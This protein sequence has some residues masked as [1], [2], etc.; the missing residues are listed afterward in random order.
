MPTVLRKLR[1][2]RV[3]GV[4][5]GANPHA[6]IVLAKRAD[7]NSSTVQR[8]IATARS[9]ISAAAVQK[10]M[11]AEATVIAKAD[12][13]VATGTVKTRA[14]GVVKVLDADAE[15]AKRYAEESGTCVTS[16]ATAAIKLADN[17]GDL[18]AD[19]IAKAGTPRSLRPLYDEAAARVKDG[20]APTRAAAIAQLATDATYAPLVETSVAEDEKVSDLLFR[21]SHRLQAM[22]RSDRAEHLRQLITDSPAFVTELLDALEPRI[23][24]DLA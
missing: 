20:R 7:A 18:L 3:D 14:E 19:A 8:A 13:L 16:D 4:D 17:D 9:A 23:G 24:A 11:K 2:T 21:I 5:R 6:H 22:E 1:I 12:Q 15:L 10:G